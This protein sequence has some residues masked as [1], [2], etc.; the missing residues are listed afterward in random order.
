MN[1]ED[2]RAAQADE[3]A[4]DSLQPLPA[5]FYEQAADYLA[6]RRAERDRLADGLDDPFGSDEVRRLTDE[7]ETAEEVVEAI[8]ERRVGKV[9]KRASLAA[10]GMP[11][12]DEGLTEEERALFADLV[13]RIEAN[14]E[15]VLDVLDGE[16]GTADEGVGSSP[17]STDDGGS[18]GDAAPP[19][20]PDDP[21]ATSGSPPLEGG[22]EVTDG[23]TVDAAGGSSSEDAAAPEERPEPDGG[24]TTAPAPGVDERVT[25]RI[26]ADV[27][28]VYG[29]DDRVYAL[30]DEDVVSLPAPNA[31]PLLDRGAAQRLG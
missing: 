17:T 22:V 14:R 11:A 4:S 25:V 7:I 23:A 3:R 20:P 9:V 18:S 27:G 8:Y 5:T 6:E 30:A 13:A 29:V 19:T 16:A 2:L 15:T 10:A 24:S 21:P 12:D 1:L 31:R 26:T 28:E